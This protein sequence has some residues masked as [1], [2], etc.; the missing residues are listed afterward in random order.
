MKTI[1]FLA[2]LSMFQSVFSQHFQLPSGTTYRAFATHYDCGSFG[3]VRAEQPQ[4]LA[5]LNTKFTFLAAD[6]RINDFLIE[7]NTTKDGEVACYY[8]VYLKRNRE[9]RTLYYESSVIEAVNESIDCDGIK[10]DLDILLDKLP[11]EGSRRGLR[12]LAA[13]LNNIE[14]T[15]CID[16]ST[17]VVFDRRYTPIK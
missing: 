16:G 3:E 14:S 10:S 4:A 13:T 8:G 7:L 15:T 5:A 2:S 12:Y 11:Y 17:R 9:D 6:K 1:I